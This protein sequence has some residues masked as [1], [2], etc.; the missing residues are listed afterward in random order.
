MLSGI[1]WVLRTGSPWRDLVLRALYDLLQ[2]VQP[3]EGGWGPVDGCGGGGL[4]RQCADD[5]QRPGSPAGAKRGVAWVVLGLTTKI[6]AV[7]DVSG[8]PLSMTSAPA[9][10]TTAAGAMLAT[11]PPDSF[12]IADKAY[13]M[14]P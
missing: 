1:L 14:D 9:H 10:D 11:L 4:R 3:Q 2:P 7:A 6:H 13:D 5:R 12:L 8:L